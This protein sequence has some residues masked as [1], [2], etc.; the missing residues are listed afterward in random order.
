MSTLTL[1]SH[2]RLTIIGG[3]ICESAYIIMLSCKI[4]KKCILG[5]SDISPNRKKDPGE[6]F[7]WQKLAKQKLGW[8]HNLELKYIKKFR[9]VKIDTLAEKN[10]FLRNLHKIGYNNIK[11]LNTNINNKYLTKAFQR[12]FRQSLIDGKV[13]RECFLISQN[14]VQDYKINLKNLFL[15]IS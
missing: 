6:K 8:W 4:S 7:P 2:I 15:T 3:K 13:D 11:G 9:K 5:H 10:R 1:K 12:R 14:L